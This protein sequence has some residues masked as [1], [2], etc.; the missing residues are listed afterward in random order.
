MT[1]CMSH[2]PGFAR[3]HEEADGHQFRAGVASVREIVE[4]WDP[5]LVVFFGSDHRRAFGEILPAI[6]VV[7]SAEG[8]GDSESPTGPYD[9]PKETARGLAAHLLGADFDVAI[10]RHIALDHGFGQTTADILG[11]LDS[12]PVIPIF[13]NC[14]TFP[15]ARPGRSAELGRAVAEYFKASD[16]RVLFIGSGG[17]SHNPPTLALTSEGLSEE[18]RRAVSAAHREAAKDDIRPEWDREM[19]GRL[20]SDDTAWTD[21]VTTEELQ[22]GGV[23]AHE[24]RTWFAAYT[25][26]GQGMKTVAY[27]PVREWLTGLGIAVSRGAYDLHM[28]RQR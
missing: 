6:S 18:E 24:L 17:M 2:S 13:I 16:E 14:A 21:D 7:L 11:G 10:T 28:P 23:G 22:A 5:T 25:A 20:E 3:D 12:R 8:L 19:L 26:G 1:L 9:V 4:A 27:E 15:L